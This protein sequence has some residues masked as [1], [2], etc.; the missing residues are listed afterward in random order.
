MS[1]AKEMWKD[2]SLPF[3]ITTAL[4]G[5]LMLLFRWLQS[6]DTVRILPPVRVVGELSEPT[7]GRLIYAIM[8]FVL[9]LISVMLSHW[10]Y[11]KN[12]E[13]LY[14]PWAL[15]TTGGILLWQAFG[16]C[17]W[18][19]GFFVTEPGKD[20]VLVH[21]PRIESFQGIPMLLLT[22]ILLM[23]MYRRL[24][25]A[26]SSYGATFLGNWFG[27]VSMIGSYTVATALGVVMEKTEWYRWSGA[28][29][30]ALCLA[31]W[32]YL[33]V[34]RTRREDRYLSSTY[35]YIAFG[36]ILYGVIGV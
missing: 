1:K 35:L 31:I 22:G 9:S 24:G 16:E 32:I 29:T 34:L 10:L 21:F 36:C 33:M 20:S 8:A 30:A 14:A 23:T 18:H 15:A 17:Q 12:K 5:V 28:V 6:I 2:S 27:H 7:W 13:Q 19:F 25:F 11:R 3:L 4:M 26:V